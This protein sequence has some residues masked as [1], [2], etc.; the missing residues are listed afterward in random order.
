MTKTQ[1]SPHQPVAYRT[2]KV[3]LESIPLALFLLF[4]GLSAIAFLENHTDRGA[5]SAAILLVAGCGWLAYALYRQWWPGTPLI[6]LSPQGIQYRVVGLKE[7]LIPWQ[8]IQSVVIRD[9]S[10]I[11]LSIRLPRRVHFRDVT[12]VR[13]SKTF[14]DRHIHAPSLLMRGP[15]WNVNFIQEGDHVD[16]A[17]HHEL[18]A[19]PPEE[20]HEA[21]VTR[22]RK[23]SG[24]LGQPAVIVTPA[25]AARRA[26][27]PLL[28]L[29]ELP[30]SL[31]SK[32]RLMVQALLTAGI[33][34]ALSNILGFWQADYQREARAKRQEWQSQL[35]KWKAEEER[36]REERRKKDAE[37]EEFWKKNGL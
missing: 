5:I 22:W 32:A 27:K 20:M 26:R 25:V 14:Y 2:D 6:T 17:L 21:V 12:A 16:V 33:V 18:F 37:W 15:G 23:F 35:D 4:L 1:R 28:R 29:P 36:S 24:H 10:T 34:F 8:Q 19:I 31:S 9:I 30:T 13:I 7:F 3:L 11:Y